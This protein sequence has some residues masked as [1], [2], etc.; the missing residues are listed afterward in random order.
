MKMIKDCGIY[1]KIR[2]FI[3]KAYFFNLNKEYI[4][5]HKQVMLSHI[6]N[7]RKRLLVKIISLFQRILFYII[8]TL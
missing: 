6:I 2:L 8:C 7:E 3:A 4:H 1:S 5:Q